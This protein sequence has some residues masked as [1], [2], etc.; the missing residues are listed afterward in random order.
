MKL[1]SY[2]HD[3][4]RH[5]M[6]TP[7]CAIWASMGMG[8]SLATLHAISTLD[9]ME[10]VLPVL[11][12]APLRVAKHTWPSE[13]AKWPIT[14][15]L[16]C[17]FIGGTVAQ[18]AKAFV[19]LADINTINFELLPQLVKE[20]GDAWP[21]RTVVIDESTRL[22]SYRLNG[23]SKRARFL[24]KVAHTKVDRMVL[25]TGTPSPQGL[26]DL[27][28]QIWFLDRGW[29]LGQ[30][31]NGFEKR[32]FRSEQ[33]GP[34]AHAKKLIALPHARTEIQEKLSDICLTID[35]KDHLNI[36]EPVVNVLSVPLPQS[37]RKTYQDMEDYFFAELKDEGVEAANAA[38][39][40]MKCLQICSGA[41]YLDGGNT[42][43]EVI[44]DEKIHAL[45]S[46]IE[47]ASGSPVLVAY[48]FKSD[49]ARLLKA[50]PQ[51]VA[52]DQNPQTIE[53]WNAGEIPV[54]LAHPQSAGHGLSLQHGGNILVFF[55][56][57]WSLENY[58]QII[59]RIGPARQKQSGYDRPV[60]VHHLVVP[61]SIDELVM[62]RL[63]TKRAVQDVLLEAMKRR[64]K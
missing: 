28:G 63:R 46:I 1:H 7:R 27:W 41:V 9:L 64:T 44:H 29:R 10:D 56:M 55:S 37:A 54:M 20:L 4:A 30:S 50:F 38:A 22:K 8:K 48:K 47:E 17:K 32:W 36:D 23:G 61:D 53:R 2:Q 12:V 59:E 11:V 24:A 3:I 40:S 62:N 15:H 6:D 21:F 14:Q 51:A 57:D 16:S 25:L 49:L 45:D 18:R 60:F 19:N 5:I 39:K 43:W 26:T 33:V 52:M 35:A 42:D 34:N 58:L 13:V 31:F